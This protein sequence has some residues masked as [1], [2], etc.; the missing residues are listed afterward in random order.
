MLLSHQAGQG[1]FV[2]H[3][4]LIDLRKFVSVFAVLLVFVSSCAFALDLN[5]LAAAALGEGEQAEPV[6]L[7]IMKFTSK[8]YDV[9]DAMAANISDFF[10]RTLFRAEGIQLLERERLDD[11]GRELNLGMS[12][13]V[14][15]ASAA[16][17]GKIA[18]CQYILLGSITNLA[19]GSSMTIIPGISVFGGAATQKQKVK[20]DLDVRVV[21][22]ETAAIVFAG[23]AE[24]ESSKSDT[25]FEIIGITQADSG[26]SNIENVAIAAATAKLAPQI[27]KALT[28]K[29]TLTALLAPAPKGK[30]GAKAAN[31]DKPAK[32]SAKSSR[33]K[34]K[35]EKVEEAPAQ[36][37]EQPAVASSSVNTGSSAKYENTSTDPATVIKSYGLSSGEANTLRI[38]HVN[39][40]KLGNTKRAYKEYVKLAEDNDKDYFAAFRAGEICVKLKQ[41]D[42][43]REWFGKALDVNPYYVPAMKAMEKL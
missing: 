39:V 26:Y 21:D 18:G 23:S 4:R 38:K 43:A 15:P 8:T 9:P 40:A 7:G 32:S 1:L 36:E 6:R 12:G 31:K 33:T 24:G 20:A 13:L 42:E 22:V 41:K 30:K 2:S 34:K 17:I 10:A 29:D 35:A 28:G 27:Q 19:R 16:R 14:D 3:R 5:D 11:A 37:T 25:A